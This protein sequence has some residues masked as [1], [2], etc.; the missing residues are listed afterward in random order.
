MKIKKE[1][2]LREKGITLIALVITIIILLIL[3]GITIRLITGDNG[4]IAQ[5]TRAKEETEKA[6]AN[7]ESVL[8]N[9]EQYIEGSTNGG[10]LTTVSGKETTNTKVQDSLGN[11]VTIPAGFR[12]VN[13]G[14]NVE[15]GIIIEDV[16]YEETKGSQFVW[17]PVGKNI[18]KADGTTFDI[19]LGRY[20]FTED[21]TISEELSKTEPTDQLKENANYTSYYTEELKDN[22]TQNIHAK[23]IQNFMAKV[24]NT[25]GYYIGRYE[26][27]TNIQRKSGTDDME[28]TQITEKSEG[29]IY[30][31]VTQSQAANLSRKMYSNSNFESDL[32]NSY[33]WD[34]TIDF[35]QKCDNRIEKSKPYSKQN[36]LNIELGLK[37][38]NNEDTKDVICNVYDMASNSLEWSTESTNRSDPCVYRGGVYNNRNTIYASSRYTAAMT[39]CYND[40]TFRPIL[41][42]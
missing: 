5:A 9:Y 17:I 34:T 11:I 10:T 18:K 39:Y 27:R 21:G 33:T 37:G 26:A 42:L 32:I 22:V 13:P 16:S 29:Y 15:D 40:I 24:N 30:N 1:Q 19:I 23:D 4:I 28:L 41:Y 8:E 36:S 6:Q 3:A 7:E 35:L 20:V 12:V 2:Q 25:G 38:T 14:D 31:W